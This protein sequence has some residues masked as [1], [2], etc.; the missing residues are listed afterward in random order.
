MNWKILLQFIVCAGLTLSAVRGEEKLPTIEFVERVITDCV[1]ARPQ[2]RKN[3]LIT[4]EDVAPAIVRLRA[5][6]FHLAAKEQG[7][8]RLLSAQ[9]PLVKLLRSPPGIKILKEIGNDSQI[10]DRL[11]R[12]MR[13]AQGR[14]LVEDLIKREDAEGVRE[15]CTASGAKR[16]AQTF[17]H[18]PACENLDVRS[19]LTFNLAE[20]LAH[21]RTMYVLAQHNLS[22]PGE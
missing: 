16:L 7:V 14:Y 4:S 17:P 18:E 21:V 11:E 8:V 22:R 6:G 19:G 5:A 10:F 2:F 13:F 1:S 20:Y 9:E 15:L 3:D 12:L